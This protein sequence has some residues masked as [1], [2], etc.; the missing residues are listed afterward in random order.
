VARMVSEDP[1]ALKRR[2]LKELK[3]LRSDA[4]FTQ[5]DVAEA[6]DWSPSKVIRIEA[7]SVSVSTTDLRALLAHYGVTDPAAVEE[8]V[9]TAKSARKRSWSEFRD[10]VTPV[11]ATFYGYEAS[12]WI[13]R[14][15]EPQLVPGLLQAE[16]YTRAILR[17]VYQLTPDKIDRLVEARAQRQELLDRDQPPKLFYLIDEAVIR[18]QVGGAAVMRRQL[19]RLEEL[20]ERPEVSI[21][22]L[23]FGSGAYPGLLGPFQLLE[24]PDPNDDPVLYL[25]AHGNQ[26]TRDEPDEFG[27]Y[28]DIFQDLEKKATPRSALAEVLASGKQPMVDV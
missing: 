28:L 12:A 11:T 18:R 10:V 4:G 24:F 3:H 16:E 19:E 14:S 13:I 26:V 20:G 2:L 7:G 6:M 5:K 1:A 17:D 21:Q 15:F 23:P 27:R 9:A 22:V 8:Y 25:E